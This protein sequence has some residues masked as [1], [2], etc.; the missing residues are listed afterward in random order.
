[1]TTDALG[2]IEVALR[3]AAKRIT[4]YRRAHDPESDELDALAE[5]IGEQAD[6]VRMVAQPV[7]V[8]LPAS[9]GP[10]P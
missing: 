7:D 9:E 2:T 1:M 3:A 8:A 10:Q 5:L 6:Q 4:R